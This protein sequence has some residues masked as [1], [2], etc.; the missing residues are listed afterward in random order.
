M[1]VRE[2]VCFSRTGSL[3]NRQLSRIDNPFGQDY[4]D[5]NRLG[6]L[7]G[8]QTNYYEPFHSMR[9]RAPAIDAAYA[10][11]DADPAYAESLRNIVKEVGYGGSNVS[12]LATDNA[13][14]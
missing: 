13:S 2:A 8:G 5:L 6:L 9:G 11:I 4:S 3:L 14:D 1:L 7:G 12:N 10:R